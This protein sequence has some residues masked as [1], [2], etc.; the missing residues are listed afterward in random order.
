MFYSNQKSLTL[1]QELIA[2]F[3]VSLL[4]NLSP[5]WPTNSSPFP[6]PSFLRF[7][8]KSALFF[9][10]WTVIVLSKALKDVPPPYSFGIVFKYIIKV[11]SL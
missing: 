4:I 7:R 6:E 10:G 1:I 8:K 2:H 3:S 5:E 9:I 11:R